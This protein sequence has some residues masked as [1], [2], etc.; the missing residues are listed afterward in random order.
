MAVLD[1]PDSCS[2]MAATAHEP[3]AGT[4]PFAT[5]WIAIEQNGPFG[6][7]ALTESH[8]DPEIGQHVA[9][10][11][12]S[13][14]IRPELI[15]SPGRHAD[16]HS[17]P[18]PRTVFVADA[19]PGQVQLAKAIID[20]PIE[21]LRFDY[22]AIAAGELLEAHPLLDPVTQPILLVCSHARRD[23]CCARKGRPIALDLANDPE[24]ADRIWECSHLGGH[25]FAATAV[26]LP[27][28]WVHGRLSQDSARQV[29]TD[30]EQGQVPWQTARGRSSLRPPAQAADLA[31]R[32][33]E[34]ITGIDATRVAKKATESTA[35][36]YLVS[37]EEGPESEVMITEAP[38]EI[39]RPESC[40]KPAVAGTYL[41]V[42]IV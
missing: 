1:P 6:R 27:H 38:V 41:S 2:A 11:C 20:D 19:R 16:D 17:K 10:V 23:V 34:N 26:Q 28:G 30:A 15:R 40:G 4:A 7:D 5:A 36:R 8:L 14:N 3:L 29:L 31:V 13:L 18:L 24:F 35:E 22:E 25:R 37:T 32:A 9:R 39:E 33:A 21:L 12:D 42:T